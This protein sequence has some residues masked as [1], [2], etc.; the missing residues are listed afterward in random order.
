MPEYEDD[1]YY[2][3]ESFLCYNLTF[4]NANNKRNFSLESFQDG[5]SCTRRRNIDD[6]GVRIDL[7]L[8]LTDRV[9][10]WQSKV[11]LATFA[12]RHSTNHVGSVLD[13]LLGVECSLLASESLADDLGVL[14]Q[15][16]VGSALGVT[17]SYSS[18]ATGCLAPRG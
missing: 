2:Y 12:W 7:L 16:H 8:G 18:K 11:N 10:H 17:C 15:G 13:G 14:G 3:M 9:K 4:C 5:C 6:S 1:H